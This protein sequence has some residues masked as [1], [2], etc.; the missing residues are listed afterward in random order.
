MIPVNKPIN[1]LNDNDNH[2]NNHVSEYNK[3]LD[4]NNSNKI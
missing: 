4:I 2:P 1:I 3:K